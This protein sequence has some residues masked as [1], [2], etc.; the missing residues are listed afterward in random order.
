MGNFKLSV[1]A[2]EDLTEIYTFGIYRFGLIEAQKYLSGMEV[3]LSNLE[4]NPFLGT[5]AS[6]LFPELRKI[7]CNQ[8]GPD[9]KA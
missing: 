4:I 5:N 2:E 9:F 1:K 3:L 6:E 7:S 8:L